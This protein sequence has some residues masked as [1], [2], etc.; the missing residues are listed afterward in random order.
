[1]GHR[2]LGPGAEQLE[3]L[4]VFGEAAELLLR[5]DRLAVHDDVVL[6]L[7]ALVRRRVESVLGQLGRE[8]RGPSVVSASDGA[9]VDLDGHAE[10]VCARVVP[11]P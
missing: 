8:T 5:E 2:F 7:G 1:M 3:H 4:T 11:T 6:A 10:I 9:I